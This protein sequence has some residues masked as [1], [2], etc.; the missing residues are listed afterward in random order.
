MKIK[1]LKIYWIPYSSKIS[2]LVS[3]EIHDSSTKY[4][5]VCNFLE[6]KSSLFTSHPL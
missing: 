4:Q 5:L 1:H 2:F 6:N 3:L